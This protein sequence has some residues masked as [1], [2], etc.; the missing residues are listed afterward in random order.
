MIAKQVKDDKTWQYQLLW[1]KRV[2]TFPPV[3]TSVEFARTKDQDFNILKLEILRNKWHYFCKN[4]QNFQVVLY[5]KQQEKN[6]RPVH[7]S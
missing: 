1:S 2:C 4:S 3:S 6:I 5:N 7:S